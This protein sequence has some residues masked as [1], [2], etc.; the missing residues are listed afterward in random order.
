MVNLSTNLSHLKYDLSFYIAENSCPVLGK[1]QLLVRY[2]PR[3]LDYIKH[4]IARRD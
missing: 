2:L 3:N 4:L 1:I